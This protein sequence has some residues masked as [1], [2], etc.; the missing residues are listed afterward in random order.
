MSV[1]SDDDSIP[2]NE[3]PLV[4][5]FK[6][7]KS[8][9]GDRT[10]LNSFIQNCNSAFSLSTEGQ[11]PS[12]FL[13]VVSQ[14][15]TNV[16]NELELNNVDSWIVLKHKL[17]LFYSHSKHLVQLH[18]ELETIRQFPNETITDY[19]KRLE[20]IKNECL[21]AEINNIS[22]DRQCEIYGI[23]RAITDTALR[24]FIIHSRPDISQILRGRDIQTL[25][26]AFSLALQEE[27]L[28]AYTRKSNYPS[29]KRFEHSNQNFNKGRNNFNSKPNYAY[30]NYANSRTN[31][32]NPNSNFNNN[33]NRQNTN[34]SYRR[35]NMNNNGQYYQ[36]PS[37]LNSNPTSNSNNQKICNYC[38]NVGHLISE[39]RKRQFNNNQRRVNHLN[40]RILTASNAAQEEKHLDQAFKTLQM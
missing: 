7:I 23:R 36:R 3:L 27:K 11:K 19:F 2:A 37:Y 5:L 34:N 4:V 21:Q 13:Y 14:L 39:C 1:I 29:Y 35:D 38:K 15:S 16:V 33:F 40:S 25:N 9:N 26:D 10:E 30:S 8:F 18:E 24:R 6:F 22:A 28:L 20:K 17:K 12:L 31:Q 32:R